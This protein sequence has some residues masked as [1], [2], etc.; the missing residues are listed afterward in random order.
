MTTNYFFHVHRRMQMTTTYFS[1]YLIKSPA[2]LKY[3][4]SEWWWRSKESTI[5]SIH[6]VFLGSSIKYDIFSYKK[7]WFLLLP[8][9]FFWSFH[10]NFISEAVAGMTV[11]SSGVQAGTSIIVDKEI[12]LYL[13]IHVGSHTSYNLWNECCWK[14]MA[15]ICSYGTE[16]ERER[17]IYVYSYRYMD[18]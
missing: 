17:E 11:K 9:L 10:L 4:S 7:G 18:G 15:T 6:G 2:F 14:N 13:C 8:A 1:T 12:L 16:S 3:V 5:D